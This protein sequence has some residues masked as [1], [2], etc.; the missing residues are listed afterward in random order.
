MIEQHIALAVQHLL[1]RGSRDNVIVAL[2]PHVLL[3]AYVG[4]VMARLQR[5]NVIDDRVER[6]P[7]IAVAVVVVVLGHERRHIEFGGK[8]NECGDLLVHQTGMFE[9]LQVETGDD[10]Q[11][12]HRQLLGRLLVRFAGGAFD[13]GARS[14]VFGPRE[15]LQAVDQRL[16]RTAAVVHFAQIERDVPERIDGGR[17]A[18]ARLADDVR[19]QSPGEDLIDDA[20]AV[21]RIWVVRRRRRRQRRCQFTL[22]P[23]LIQ[24]RVLAVSVQHVQRGNEELLGVLLLVARQMARMVPDQMEQTMQR[25]WHRHARI[26]LLEQTADLADQ[27]LGRQLGAALVAF[28]QEV[29]AQQWRMDERLHDAVHEAGGAEIH[30]AA[31]TDG[32]RGGH[33]T[34]A[35][36]L[37]QEIEI[38]VGRCPGSP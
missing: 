23:V 32:R 20:G 5:S 22:L 14:E 21:H 30:E 38:D 17:D 28:G 26:E 10:R 31:Q 11:G 2:H 18:V 29:V 13:F 35:R 15:S 7:E 33:H 27:T 25:Q 8:R 4:R 24:F 6:I 16:G 9:A 19:L 12:A 34:T 1:Q 37:E 3:V 36:M